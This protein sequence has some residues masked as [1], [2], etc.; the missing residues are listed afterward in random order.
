MDLMSWKSVQDRHEIRAVPQ[1]PIFRSAPPEAVKLKRWH[2]L[3]LK[4]ALPEETQ[5]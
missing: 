4:R 3:R 2:S 1:T 5:D